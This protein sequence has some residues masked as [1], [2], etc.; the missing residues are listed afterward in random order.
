VAKVA[1]VDLQILCAWCKE[2]IHQG[3]P[4]G[5]DQISHG[6]CCPCKAKYFP[7]LEHGSSVECEFE[8]DEREHEVDERPVAHNPLTDHITYATTSYHIDH[9][10]CIHCRME[11]TLEPVPCDCEPN[12]ADGDDDRDEVRFDESEVDR[13]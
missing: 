13:G 12:E 5:P 6:M 10:K 3:H 8:L 2:V 11:R 4:A 7:T 1:A 9:E